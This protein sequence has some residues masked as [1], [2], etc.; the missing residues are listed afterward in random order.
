VFHAFD[1][2][3]RKTPLLHIDIARRRYREVIADRAE[4]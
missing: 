3:S 1:K 2:A 4:K